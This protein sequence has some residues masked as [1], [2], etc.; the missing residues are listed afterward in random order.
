MSNQ[1]KGVR[2]NVAH[3]FISAKRRFIYLLFLFY[4]A[5]HTDVPVVVIHEKYE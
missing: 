2:A 3:E 5:E 1:D 4:K